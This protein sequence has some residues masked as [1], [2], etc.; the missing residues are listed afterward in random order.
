MCYGSII[1]HSNFFVPDMLCKEMS[2]VMLY[3]N[4][5]TV[6]IGAANFRFTFL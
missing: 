5:N 4:T 1:I 6:V 2:A 3:E